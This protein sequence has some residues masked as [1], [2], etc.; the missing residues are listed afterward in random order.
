MTNIEWLRLARKAVK[1]NPD[2]AIKYLNEVIYR[3]K[4]GYADDSP[5]TKQQES[6]EA[7]I[8]G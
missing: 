4:T 7:K 3:L 8:R 2:M 5:L 6:D 1:D